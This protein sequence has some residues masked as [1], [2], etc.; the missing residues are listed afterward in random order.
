[1]FDTIYIKK[2]LPLT[3]ELKA[4]NVNW[5]EVDFQT[6]DLY[7]CL[8]T[9]E[10]TKAGRLL[11]LK[12]ERKW[13]DDDNAFLKGYLEVVSEEWVDT[14]FH[15]TVNFYTGECDNKN[16]HWNH[17]KDSEQLSWEDI[18]KIEGNDWWIEFEAYFTKGQL[19]DIKLI[20]ANKTPIKERLKSSK[21]WAIEREIEN[22]KPLRRIT[23]FLRKFKTYRKIINLVIRFVNWLHSSMTRCLYRM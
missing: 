1:M 21:E 10:I 3:K 11:N 9:Y 22:K 15:G 16:H 5:N 14:H 13:V 6:K 19:D 18:E 2:K 23:N 4:L 8:E 12:Q 17:L 20:K 7:N